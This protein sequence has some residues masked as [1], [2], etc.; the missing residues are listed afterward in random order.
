MYFPFLRGKQ[1]ELIALRELCPKIPG[2]VSPIIEPVKNSPTFG[3]TIKALAKADCNFNIVINPIEGKFKSTS[4]ILSVIYENI[5]S[6]KNFQLSIIVTERVDV[7]KLLELCK[8]EKL[9]EIN[10]SLVHYVS[11]PDIDTIIELIESH[12]SVRYNIIHFRRTHRRY[13]RAFPKDSLV[14]LDDYFIQQ[15]R[16]A[17][18]LDNT[19]EKFTEEHIFHKEDGYFGFS[20]YSTLGENYSES[21]FA[22][23]AVAIHVTY[24]TAGGEEIRVKHFVSDSNDD[25]YDP[26]GKFTEAVTKFLKWYPT[27]GFKTEALD[28]L[29]EYGESGHF[30]GLGVLKKLSIKNHIELISS[31]V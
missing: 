23:Y 13:Y 7:K 21:G 5:G 31:M 28:E 4:S 2:K 11:R 19:D 30:P 20:D 18:Y 8:K 10:I 26:A 29:Y 27:A 22:P 17:D 3:S 9:G 1:F 25:W 24:P 6:Y 16:N 15:D 12:S 14:T